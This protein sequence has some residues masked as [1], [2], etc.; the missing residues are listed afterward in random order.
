VKTYAITIIPESPFGTTLKGDTIFGHFCWQAVHNP[1]L[2]QGGFFSWIEQYA[3]RPFAVFSSAWPQLARKGG[4]IVYCLPRPAISAHAAAGPDRRERAE[5]R[6]KE[7]KKKWLLLA[8]GNLQVDPSHC[9]IVNDKELFEE[10]LTVLSEPRKQAMQFAP[11]ELRKPFVAADQAHNSINRLTMTTGKGFDPFNM[12]NSHYLP[13]L[14]LVIFV[15]VDEDALD[16]DGLRIGLERIGLFGF[17]RDASAGLGRFSV[18]EIKEWNW[19]RPGINQGCY[20]LAPCVPEK[21]RF[22]DH[23]ALP[24]TRFGRHGDRLALSGNPFKNPVIMADEGAVFFPDHDNIPDKP[25]IGTA[26]TGLSLAEKRTVG[27]GYAL[28]LPYAGR[29]R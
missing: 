10:Y 19:L 18:G 28:Y 6:K 17:G 29:S 2:L 15:A 12:E 5:T 20:T 23:F 24:F 25:Y 1:G 27:Q 9:R 22:A 26:V 13:G 11:D 7:K 14:D 21:D 16:A 4:D 8:Q 3:E